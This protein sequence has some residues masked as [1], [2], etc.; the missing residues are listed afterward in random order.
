MTIS[1]TQRF[2]ILERD[3]FTC[4][5]CGR[6]APETELEVD[7]L[8]P[9]SKGG[10]DEPSN[11]VAACRTCNQGKKDRVL[12][13]PPPDDE[14]PWRS[15][16]GKFFFVPG[17]A[18]T[19]G[20]ILAEPTP[21]F[22]VVECK[23]RHAY[24]AERITRLVPVSEIAAGEWRLFR[25][26]PEM[27]AGLEQDR[28]WRKWREAANANPTAFA[29]LERS[30]DRWSWRIEDCPFCHAEHRHAGGPLDGD[31]RK[32]LGDRRARCSDDEGHTYQLTEAPF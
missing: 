11:L 7:H 2:D 28:R 15:L 29:V 30:E 20:R 21:G 10:S 32:L 19:E 1:L 4:R 8:H 24:M 18:I 31:P 14:T 22:V 26:V 6:R 23:E 5:F 9:R 13:P 25:T 12:M 3:D 27:E 17:A 16:A